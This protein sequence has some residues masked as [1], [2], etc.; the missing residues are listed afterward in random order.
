M[1][2]FRDNQLKRLA[3]HKMVAMAVRPSLS[4]CVTRTKVLVIVAGW[5][6]EAAP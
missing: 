1:I 5:R 2:L 6:K 4:A 3:G